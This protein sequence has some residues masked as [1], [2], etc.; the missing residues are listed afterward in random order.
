MSRRTQA[1]IDADKLRE[2]AELCIEYGLPAHMPIVM[3]VVA[4][5]IEK[6]TRKKG[7]V[8]DNTELNEALE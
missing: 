6:G 8:Q 3:T 5:S 7:T 1:Q 4:D 2:A